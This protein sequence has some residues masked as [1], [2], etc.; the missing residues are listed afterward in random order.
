MSYDQCHLD[1][2]KEYPYILHIIDLMLSVF[3]NI[4]GFYLNYF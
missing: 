4:E 1:V 2:R 3:L